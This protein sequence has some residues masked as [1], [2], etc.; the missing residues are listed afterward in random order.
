[1]Y[2]RYALLIFILL[3]CLFFRSF[4]LESFYGFGHD[5]DLLSWIAK[6][7][8]IDRHFRLIGQ[9]TSIS[10]VFIGPLFYDLVSVVFIL[11]S[12]NPLSANIVTLLISLFTAYSFYF[13]ISKFFNKPAGFISAFLYSVSIGAAS[14]DRWECLPN[15]L[16][17]GQYGIYIPYFQFSRET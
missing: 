15:R 4:R 11:F 5:Q 13:V 10:G 2:K 12:M 16:F 7:Q 1:M 9:E 6:D 3:L 17:F 8:V 14:F